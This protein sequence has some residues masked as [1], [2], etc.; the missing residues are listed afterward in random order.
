MKINTFS[1]FWH[2]FVPILSLETIS[3]W[4]KIKLELTRANQL[5]VPYQDLLFLIK[6]ETMKIEKIILHNFRSIR[7]VEMETANYSLL[8]GENNSGK[9]SILTALRMFYEDS[10]A[11]Y[12]RD[13]DFPKFQ[14]NDNESWIEL[15]FKTMPEEQKSLKTEY[16]SKDLILRV[17]RYFQSDKKDLVKTAQSNI[18]G[19]ESGKLSESLFYGAKNISQAKLG[20]VVYIPEVNQ[21][22]DTLKVSGPSPFRDMVNFVMKR[23][24]QES[25]PF[26]SLQDSFE[27]FNSDFRE[28]ASK[29]GLSIH[30]LE[31]QINSELSYWEIK[32]GVE[33]NPVRPEDVVKNLIGHYIEDINL[34]SQ[35]V[36]I[37]SF[38]QGLQRHLIYTLV[39]LSSSFK[40]PKRGEK[41][42]FSPDFTLILFEEPEAF[43]HPGQQ[44]LLDSS[45][46]TLAMGEGQQVVISTHSPQFVSRNIEDVPAICRLKKDGPISYC[47]QV[48]G[49]ARDEIINENIGLYRHFCDMLQDPEVA[50]TLKNKI[51]KNC[52]GED[53]PDEDKKLEEESMKFLFWLN[54]ERAALFFAKHVVICEG[55]TEKVLL[56]YLVNERWHGIKSEQI[57]FLDAGGKFNIH[58]YVKL[59]NC[60]GIPHSILMDRDKDHEYHAALNQYIEDNLAITTFRL[61][62]F[63][64]DLE[65]FLNIPPAARRDL[66]ALHALTRLRSGEIEDSKIDELRKVVNKLLPPH[67][68]RS[69]HPTEI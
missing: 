18:Y 53:N 52:L 55:P 29:D 58:R 57:Y 43:L 33:I 21:V 11:K 30:S 23:A 4:L 39:R 16:Q 37:N 62:A 54:V 66:K 27:K 22:S 19:Y 24:V 25:E 28:E 2:A 69:L 32:F 13:S 48:L 63:D 10:G 14:T 38:G 1:L 44:I 17:R 46:R 15:H 3:V 45:L 31:K 67:L 56:D 41:K 65:T 34:D 9:T 60:L 50:D 12:H 59:L 5:E 8:V 68:A 51:R 26:K 40:E 20:K 35:R 64:N 42:E 36:N 7:D 47:Y 61:E 6:G 49:S